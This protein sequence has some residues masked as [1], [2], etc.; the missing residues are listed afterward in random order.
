MKFLIVTTALVILSFTVQAQKTNLILFAEGGEKFTLHLNSVIQNRTP[1]SN[2]KVVGLQA[3]AV[4][5]LVV[6]EGSLPQ[7]KQF[8]A[9]QPDE[10]MTFVIRKG[11]KGN[12][13]L[14][15]FSTVPVSQQPTPTETYTTTESTPVTPSQETTS[16]A[17]KTPQAAATTTVSDGNSTAVNISLNGGVSTANASI[18][19]AVGEQSMQSTGT[20]ATVSVANTQSVSTTSTTSE[21][22]IEKESAPAVTSTCSLPMGQ[23]EFERAK[24][25][26][27][28]KSFPEEKMTIC[29]Q[30]IKVNCFNVKQVIGIME[31][32]TYEENKL[33]VAKMM[34]SKTVDKGNYYQINDALTYSASVDELN[35][36][37]EQQ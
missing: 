16:V 21:K 5:A 25:S 17:I 11:N 27:D 22:R 18:S 15:L 9:L 6:F 8:V 23:G 14:R 3:D 37:L 31:L 1:Q 34:Y 10:E 20:S 4:Q 7:L 13:V 24:E 12:Y 32:F 29:K 26:I 19:I 2:V 36:F 33:A 35:R 30:L 28:A